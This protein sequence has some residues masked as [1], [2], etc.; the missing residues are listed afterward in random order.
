MRSWAEVMRRL[1]VQ[2]SG[3]KMTDEQHVRHSLILSDLAPTL[4]GKVLSSQ[5]GIACCTL[6]QINARQGIL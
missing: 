5:I 4:H 6:V 2:V 1:L 3:G